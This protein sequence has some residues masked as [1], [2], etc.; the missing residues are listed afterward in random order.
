MAGRISQEVVETLQV[1]GTAN[2][3]ITQEFAETLEVPLRSGTNAR[4]TQ[5]VIEG[6]IIPVR[7]GASARITQQFIEFLYQLPPSMPAISNTEWV[8]STEIF[9]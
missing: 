5:Q 7:A 2:A 6:V 1:P 9:F 3:R 8:Y 4:I